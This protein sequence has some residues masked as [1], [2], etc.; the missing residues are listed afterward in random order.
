M[1]ESSSLLKRMDTRFRGYDG[2]S[3]VSESP[4][5]VSFEIILLL[6]TTGFPQDDFVA[7]IH[8][9]NLED[10]F[11]NIQPN[12]CNV[13]DQPLA[14]DGNLSFPAWH[15]RCR[16]GRGESMSLDQAAARQGR[17]ACS[18]WLG[19]DTPLKRTLLACCQATEPLRRNRPVSLPTTDTALGTSCRQRKRPRQA[20]CHHP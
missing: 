20:Q 1:R 9:V 6:T 12:T 17:R 7:F 19:G 4:E 18:E 3:Q 14:V 16:W 10:M 13:H 8:T 11:G 5:T 15:R 2:K